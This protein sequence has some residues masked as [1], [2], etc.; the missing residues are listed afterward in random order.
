MIP[1]TW[2]ESWEHGLCPV[3]VRPH[4]LIGEQRNGWHII[5]SKH[6]NGVWAWSIARTVTSPPMSKAT[7]TIKGYAYA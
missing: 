6:T 7:R 5:G 3:C 4:P 1:W 2:A